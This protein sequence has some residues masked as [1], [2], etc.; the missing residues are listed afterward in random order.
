MGRCFTPLE[1]TICIISFMALSLSF[2]HSPVE[3][4][5][6]SKRGLLLRVYVWVLHAL[7]S[8]ISVIP[9][10]CPCDWVFVIAPLRGESDKCMHTCGPSHPP[11]PP[12]LFTSPII[13]FFFSPRAFIQPFF[14]S[15]HLQ[16]SWKTSRPIFVSCSFKR[17]GLNCHQWLFSLG[18]GTPQGPFVAKGN[19]AETGPGRNLPGS[20][21]PQET[22]PPQRPRLCHP[23]T[24]LPVFRPTMM[25]W[26]QTS[27]LQHPP[28]SFN[29]TASSS[30]LDNHLIQCGIG[31][32][33]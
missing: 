9:S 16:N 4:W 2:Q 6:F 8:A 7:L 26:P 31:L 33:I 20:D 3:F 28:F 15:H 14:S 29:V 17:T 23:I 24:D 12:Q 30:C 10:E 1:N 18:F 21:P 19:L 32:Y 27:G 11:L 5:K 13:S 25:S 22:A